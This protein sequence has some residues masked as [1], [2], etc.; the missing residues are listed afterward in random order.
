MK[1][2]GVDTCVILRLLI[3]EP[4]KQAITAKSFI[5]KCYYDGIDVCVSDMVVG[6]A[7][8]AI[9]YHYD[10]PKEEAIHALKELLESPMIT[11]TGHALSVL[12]GYHGKGAG[13]VDRLIRMDLLDHA[14]EIKTFDRDFAKLDNVEL[15]K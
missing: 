5:E 3:G 15:L 13:M 2:I 14:Y 4:E 11:T 9:C 10:V 8:H 7:Y 12:S 6:E 1:S